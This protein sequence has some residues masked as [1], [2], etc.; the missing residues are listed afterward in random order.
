ME[1]SDY[2]RWKFRRC[3]ET[4]NRYNKCY[5]SNCKKCMFNISEDAWDYLHCHM[6]RLENSGQC[7]YNNVSE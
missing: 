2:E 4:I 3:I 5:E 6:M 7:F 1:I